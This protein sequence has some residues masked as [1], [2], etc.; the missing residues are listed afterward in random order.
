MRLWERLKVELRTWL[1]V[2]VPS[3]TVLA[4]TYGLLTSAGEPVSV[5]RA[6]SLSAVWACVSLISGAVASLPLILYRRTDTGRERFEEHP[7]FDVLGTRP[8]PVQSVVSFWEA[9][10]TAL[11]LRGNA[12]AMLTR[13]DDERVRALWYVNPDR[14]S[15][16]LLKTGRLRYKVSANTGMQQTIAAEGMLHIT[17][18]MSDDG[19]LGRSVI[20]TFRETLGLSLGLERYASEFFAN[21]ATPQGVLTYPGHLSDKAHANLKRSVDETRTSRGD[22][23]GRWCSRRA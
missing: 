21:A 8:N 12:Y 6:V 17:G 20:T 11:L 16:D 22:G 19:Y 4:N 2:N 7:L 5:A 18:P 14:V 10:V 1:D 15:V 9:M 13:D 23:T 3:Q